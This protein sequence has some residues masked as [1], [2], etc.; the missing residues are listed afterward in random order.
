M[1]ERLGRK[2]RR[3]LR[4]DVTQGFPA[5]DNLYYECLRCSDFVP[6]LP[7]D[8]IACSCE[9]IAIDVDYGRVHVDDPNKLRAFLVV[10]DGSPGSDAGIAA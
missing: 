7:D 10:D 5:G 8:N 3:Y 1:T 9:N 6:S 4:F 2:G